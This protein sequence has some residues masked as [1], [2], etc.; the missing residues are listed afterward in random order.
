MVH[1]GS[2]ISIM[3]HDH[4]DVFEW[5]VLLLLSLLLLLLLLMLLLLLLLLLWSITL[6]DDMNE[7][8]RMSLGWCDITDT[9]LGPECRH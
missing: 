3:S 9:D 6:Y 2:L 5:Y 1:L 7:N 8:R 4:D